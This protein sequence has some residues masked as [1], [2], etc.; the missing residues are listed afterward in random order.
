MDRFQIRIEKIRTRNRYRY[1]N[2]QEIMKTYQITE[3]LTCEATDEIEKALWDI[4][5][6]LDIPTEE[7]E[8]AIESRRRVR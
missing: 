6:E 5:T 7:I 3:D 4:K 1:I 2:D 8:L